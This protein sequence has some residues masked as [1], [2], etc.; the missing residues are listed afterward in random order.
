MGGENS[1]HITE[2]IVHPNRKTLHVWLSGGDMQELIEMAPK[3]MAWGKKMGCTD[4]TIEGRLGWSVLAVKLEK[5]G[6]VA[7][8]AG[9]SA[10][11]KTTQSSTTTTTPNVPDWIANDVRSNNARTQG[12]RVVIRCVCCWRIRSAKAGLCAGTKIGQNP[13]DF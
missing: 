13:Q 11:K 3:L 6:K 1:F 2:I 9:E 5:S 7:G 10:S 4:A 12:L 8:G